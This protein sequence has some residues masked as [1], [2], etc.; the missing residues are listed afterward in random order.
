[1][2][3]AKPRFRTIKDYLNYDDGTDTRY[4]LVNG[5]LIELPNEDPRNLL[6]AR[7]LLVY[8]VQMGI[9]IERVGDKQQI[10]VTSSEA[11]AREPDLTIHSE[12]S[13]AAILNQTQSL[14]TID[15]P[16]PLLVIE[17][18]SPGKPGSKNY[19]RDY[20]DK[21]KEY[22]ARGILE[23]WLID[24]SRSVVT[25]LYLDG[26]QYREVGQFQDGDRVVSPTFPEF[27]LTAEQVLTTRV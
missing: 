21:R 24:P 20:I 26:E 25:V 9:V 1:M 23:Y 2:T 6:I 22:A 8:F 14:L 11:T 17:V 15:M 4:E 12:A 7:F 16:A 13:A 18:V 3:Q 19:D 10:A 27:Q 5:E